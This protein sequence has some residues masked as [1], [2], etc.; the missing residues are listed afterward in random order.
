MLNFLI[1]IILMGAGLF[2]SA[3]FYAA[4]Q[5]L[6]ILAGIVSFFVALFI[7]IMLRLANQWEMAVILRL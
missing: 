3:G 7:S 5:G 1:F 4:S 2:L 6:G